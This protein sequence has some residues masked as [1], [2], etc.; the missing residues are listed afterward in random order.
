MLNAQKDYARGTG[1]GGFPKAYRPARVVYVVKVQ[2]KERPSLKTDYLKADIQYYASLLM[3]TYI[4]LFFFNIVFL[5]F[6]WEFLTI[7]SG[8][9]HFSVLPPF[10]M[11]SLPRKEKIK[12]K[13][14]VPGVLSIY[15]LED[16]QTLSGLLLK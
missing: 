2:A 16:G 4:V 8:H 12:I 3:H 14:E 1:T 5:L 7:Y 11:T 10:P 9:F 15:S 6:L 13:K